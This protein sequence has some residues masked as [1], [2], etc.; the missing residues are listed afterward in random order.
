MRSGVRSAV[1]FGVLIILLTVGAGGAGG[2][3][4]GQPTWSAGDVG[5]PAIQGSATLDNG[6]FTITAGGTRIGNRVDQFHFVYQVVQGDVDI[7]ARVDSVSDA[8]PWSKAGVMIR[9]SLSADAAHGYALV[10]S[11]MGTWFQRRKR[12]GGSTTRTAGVAVAPPEWVRLVR[13]GNTVSAYTSANGASWSLIASDTIQLGATAYVGLAV[14]SHNASTATTAMLSQT[15]V[16]PLGLPAGQQAADIGSP[17]I[18]GSTSYAN[19][20]YQIHAGG[21]DIWG[22]SDQFHYIYQQA[23]GDLDLRVRVNS[24]TLSASWA[25]A[26]VMIRETLTA[27][28]THAYSALSGDQGFV[29]HR[30]PAANSTTVSTPGSMRV[31]PGW[32]RLTRSGTL[33][34]AYES[35]DGQTWSPIASDSIPMA[36]TVYVG[37]AVTSQNPTTATDVVADAFTVT[38]TGPENQPPAVSLSSPANNATFTAPA[39]I[40]M[41]AN[42]SDPE[43]QLT[44]VEFYN[45]PTLLGTDTAA[46]YSFTWPSVPVGTYSLTARAYDADGLNATSA[47]VSITVTAAANQPPT[48]SITSPANNATFTAPASIT[49]TANA[50]DAENQL[51]RVEFYNGSTLLGTDA[52]APY[53]FTWGNVAP[54]T[55]LLRGIAFDSAG[56]SGSS[57]TVTV[58]V[59]GTASGL[60]AAYGLN[61]GTGT[62]VNDNSGTGLTGS[63][64]GASWVAGRYGQALS[65]DGASSVVAFGDVDLTGSFTVMGWMQTR[66]LYSNSCASFV[67]K[68]F[69]YGFEVCNGSLRARI[70]SGNG[71]ST[72][73]IRPL[74]TADLNVWKHIAMTYNGTTVRLYIDGVLISSATGAHVSNNNPLLFGRWT[75]ASEYWNGVVDEVRIYSRMLSQAE[76]QTDMTTPI[77]SGPANQ[78]P[79]ATLTEPANGAT[80]S[81]PANITLTATA[82]DADGS[83]ARVDFYSGGTLLG[84]DTTAPYSFTW[85]DVA[86]GTYALKATAVDDAGASGSSSVASVTVTGPNQPPTVSITSPSTNATFA[87][88]ASIAITANAADPENQLTRVEFYNGTTLL[89]TDTTAPYSF[90]WSSVPAGTYSLTAR[91][92]D[93]AGLNT[94]S[95]GVS[96]TVTAV[97]S[98]P[99]TGVIFQAS[100]DHAIVVSYQVD[101]FAAGADPATA[102]PIATINVGKP[103]PDADNDITVAIAGFFSALAPGTY[104]LTVASLNADGMSRS[105]PAVTF[106]R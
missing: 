55:Y 100:V 36:D 95:A 58:T 87:A 68:A 7:R 77:G 31:A 86:A 17:A 71:W 57:A 33:F 70:G 82:S 106:V 81:A 73:A 35:I 14:S 75:P 101:V 66:S 28:S 60:V 25:K 4:S 103:A 102:A 45:G 8:D 89:G 37:I 18:A 91:A 96:I 105:A 15:S 62:T 43:N 98:Q 39:S 38:Q 76:V 97:A 99:P 85:P 11:E 24:M 69:D 83:V 1:A 84:S 32:V 65:L 63:M 92:Y 19:G 27:G 88:P 67:M 9:G 13:R 41:T 10:S 26:G 79:I 72:Y 44:R 20:A 5:A 29:F 80:F 94:T 93:A 42:A 30:R 23:S 47:A 49:I 90:T 74:T 61:E 46:P 40:A 6:T 22:T 3:T 64:S 52:S 50:A 104:Q 78:A 56:A 34:T 59:S 53:A 51:T 54:G 16:T 21:V 2:Q 48:V 12:A